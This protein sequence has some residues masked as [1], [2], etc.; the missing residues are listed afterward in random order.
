[1]FTA[2]FNARSSWNQKNIYFA[3]KTHTKEILTPVHR[4][5][6][7]RRK[8]SVLSLMKTEGSYQKL[9]KEFIEDAMV[10]MRC[11]YR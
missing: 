10:I 5:S 1:M 8:R 7:R 2:S 9:M 6:Q 3:L 4:I 11:H